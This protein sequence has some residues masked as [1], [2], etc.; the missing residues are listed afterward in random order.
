MKYN[1]VEKV[2]EEVVVEEPKVFV[3]DYKYAG[4]DNIK[5]VTVNQ[6]AKLEADLHSLRMV[7]V[8]N[9]QNP[10]VLV[11]SNRT[12][13]QEISAVVSAIRNLEA[14]FASVL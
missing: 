11:A 6:L 12:I 13:S 3:P 7:Y 10:D 1:E 2:E 4:V 9:G 8:A 5:A 14:Y